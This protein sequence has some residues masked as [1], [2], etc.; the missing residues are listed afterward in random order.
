ML[1]IP[2]ALGARPTITIPKALAH[3][4]SERT[5]AWYTGSNDDH[6]RLNV[7]EVKA[8]YPERRFYVRDGRW[9]RFDVLGAGND[10]Q[11]TQHKIGKL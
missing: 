6:I 8:K 4:Y 7:N 11:E 5:E 1:L 2:S 9:E 3:R 10:L